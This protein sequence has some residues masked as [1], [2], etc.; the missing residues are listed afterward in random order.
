MD[1]KVYIIIAKELSGE[2]TEEERRELEAWLSS[3]VANRKDYEAMRMLWQHSDELLAAPTFNTGAAWQKVSGQINTSTNNQGEVKHKRTIS[4]KGW[5][6]YGMA[7]AAVL[8]IGLLVWNPLNNDTITEIADAG[9]KEVILPDDSRITL[10]EGS[11][12]SYPKKFDKAERLVALNGE[13]FFE[14]TR[15]EKQPFVIDAGAATVKVL[16][17]SFDVLCTP[18]EAYVTVATGKVQMTD[19]RNISSFVILTP[20]EKGTLEG[21]TLNEENVSDENYLYWKTGTLVFENKPLQYVVAE[22][23]RIHKVAI[24]FDA[25]ATDV[26]RAQLIN[27]SFGKQ[28]V[29]DMLTELCLVAKCRWSKNGNGYII[30]AK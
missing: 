20:G 17:T 8:L 26:L 14:V 27:I 22:L 29:E 1:E 25:S 3:D 15:N 21:N 10:K 24:G 28:P 13:A 9:N 19:A 30:S 23:A 7:A 2:A 4:L 16:G 11:S 5:A 18:N 12:I 6:R